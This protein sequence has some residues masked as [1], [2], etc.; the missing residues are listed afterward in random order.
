MSDF[1]FS[2][3]PQTWEAVDSDTD[4]IIADTFSLIVWNDEVNTFE[5]VIETLMEVCGH[6][7]EQAEQCALFVHHKGKY[8]VKKG[9][10][11]TLKPM[12]NSITDRGI[13]ATVEQNN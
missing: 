13:G 5:W 3:S 10:Y 12:C 8:A 9:D 6:S 7:L 11:D 2:N 1:Y 4:T